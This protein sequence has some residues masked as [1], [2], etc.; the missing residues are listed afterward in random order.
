LAAATAVKR[1]AMHVHR[2]PRNACPSLAQEPIAD[3]IQT[4]GIVTHICRVSKGPQVGHILDSLES[5]EEIIRDHAPEF[6]DVGKHPSS[7]RGALNC[8]SLH[9]SMNLLT[10]GL[11][12]S[13]TRTFS[14]WRFD[15]ASQAVNP[16]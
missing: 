11:M 10:T 14:S 5:V 1:V 6:G 16:S 9:N 2:L 4:G 13:M 15:L 3:L 8:D 7:S 12:I